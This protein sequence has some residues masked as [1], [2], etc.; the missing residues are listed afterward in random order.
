MFGI[1]DYW[2]FVGTGILLNLIPGQDTLF[3]LGRAL[4]GGQRAGVS[5]ALG[6]SVGS[7]CHTLAAAMGFSALISASAIAF[8]VIKLLGAAYLIVLGLRLLFG[9]SADAADS[10]QAQVTRQPTARSCFRQGVLTN[11][12]NPKVALF[13][14]ALLP[15]FIDPVSPA[16]TVAFLALGATFITTGTLWCLIL[17]IAAARLRSFFT[18]KP[19]VRTLL[20]RLTGAVFVALGVRLAWRR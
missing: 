15:Q 20:D 3:S 11:V 9:P 8:T 10:L 4:S 13:F 2:V 7:L 19:F 5:A 12:L 14:L 1:H 18:R 17:A 6:I 16:K